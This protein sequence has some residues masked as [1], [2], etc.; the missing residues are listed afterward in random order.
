MLW[1][2]YTID[3]C[4]LSS[5]WHITSK[6]MFAGS[7][8]GTIL[9]VIVLEALRRASKEYD[10]YIVRS[11]TKHAANMPTVTQGSD[12]GKFV[13]AS[14]RPTAVSTTP[15]IVQQAIRALLHMLQFAVAYI[16]MLL[17][18]YY[19]GY[20]I[21]CIF[22]GAFIGSFIFSWYPL[23]GGQNAEDREITYCC[24]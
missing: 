12:D 20:I 14:T 13:S 11:A 3:A 10:S 6:G 2:W 23:S 21:I 7:C 24:G 22:I 5:S 18:M 9:L 17:A 19:N 4:F 8:I 16:I 1:N 15:T